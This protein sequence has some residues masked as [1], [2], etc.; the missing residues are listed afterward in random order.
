MHDQGSIPGLGTEPP[1]QAAACRSKKKQ[2]PLSFQR[3]INNMDS[4]NEMLSAPF[5]VPSLK[6]GMHFT[7]RAYGKTCTC[8]ISRA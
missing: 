5:P 2:K 4:I 1:H 3:G 8:H 6:P 7:L